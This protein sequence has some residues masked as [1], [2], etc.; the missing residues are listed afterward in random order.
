MKK[1]SKIIRVP[2]QYS[3]VIDQFSNKLNT[4]KTD[5]ILIREKFFALDFNL[6]KKKKSN[7]SGKTVFEL[8]FDNI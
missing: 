1:K 4:P 8:E 5:A 3:Q 7:G 2:E 6:K